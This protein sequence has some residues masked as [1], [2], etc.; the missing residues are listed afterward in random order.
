MALRYV[1]LSLVATKPQSGYDIVKSF[2]HSIGHIW[3]ASHQQVYRELGKL[4]KDAW[5]EFER[6]AQN[7]KPDRKVYSITAEGRAHLDK[8]IASAVENPAYRSPILVRMLA[9]P[10]VGPEPLIPAVQEARGDYE[11][12][13]K[14]YQALA[15]YYASHQNKEDVDLSLRMALR[16]AILFTEPMLQW[17]DETVEALRTEQHKT[18][19][20][21]TTPVP[22]P[23]HALETE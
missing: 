7:D 2:D 22:S 19:E 21:A 1:I 3:Q 23:Q 10:V 13:L 11:E 14:S 6:E 5:L 20:A 18:T 17:C 16:M 8:W 15:E 9:L 12:K 4:A